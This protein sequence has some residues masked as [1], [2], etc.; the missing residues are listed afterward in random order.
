MRIKEIIKEEAVV[1]VYP[2]NEKSYS[3]IQ[4]IK[5]VPTEF[6]TPQEDLASQWRNIRYAMKDSGKTKEQW[7]AGWIG[8]NINPAK[9][10]WHKPPSSYGD[11]VLLIIDGHHR[12][13]A[14]K[15]LNIPLRVTV[16]SLGVMGK[17][18]NSFIYDN[19]L[20]L[21]KYGRKYLK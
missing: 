8:K 21:K 11:A 1:S 17:E 15:I 16:E 13:I 7:A 2:D 20:A 4:E 19:N 9:I 6:L 18:I 12:Y 14:A 10:T 3:V 5:Y